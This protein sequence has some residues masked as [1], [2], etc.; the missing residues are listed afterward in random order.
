MTYR[1]A[2]VGTG[3]N[4][5]KRDRDGYAMAYRHAGGYERLDSC[6][7][8]AC[9]DIVRENAEAFAKH[10]DL[11]GVYEDHEEMLSEVE[12]DIVSI[13][14]PP[15][16]HA[17]LVI[18][19]AKAPSV[20]AVH[21][22]KPMATTWEDCRRM[23]EVCEQEDV[24]LTIDHQ[25]RFSKPVQRAKALLDAG[26]IGELRRVEW[27]EVNLFDAGAHLFDL[28]DLFTD[29]ERVEWVLSGIDYARENR[30]FG[31]INETR[32]I[33]Q[34][35]Y[36]DGTMG[37]ASTAEEGPTLVDAYLRLVGTDGEIEIQ[38]DDGPPLRLRT[39]GGW[40]AIDTD[41]ETV[42][43]Y[44]PDIKTAAVKKLVGVLPIE[45]ERFSDP[46]THYERAIEHLVS[47]LSS[48]DE[49]IISGRSVLRG[50]EL[51]FASWQSVRQR[52]RAHLPLDIDDNPLEAMND[53]GVLGSSP[54]WATEEPDA[55]EEEELPAD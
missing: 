2:I 23:V 35:R 1:V 55:T 30:W 21:C 12:P 33:S 9:A 40:K 20:E 24:Q 7:L 15:A 51:V 54:T 8:V 17:E 44:S 53:Q 28:C 13:C 32:A 26:E 49:P 27:S 48:G 5:E 31:A 6:S 45:I 19:C 37:F 38:P 25:R 52:G 34:W 3:A 14:V 11:D 43:S 22:E 10:Y 16:V 4:P 18:D 42:Y 46:P 50:T 29:G 36:A 47:S 39:D 41:N